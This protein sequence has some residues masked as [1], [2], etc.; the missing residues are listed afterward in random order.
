MGS[1]FGGRNFVV[2]LLILLVV[3]FVIFAVIPR[4]G[5]SSDIPLLG[6]SESLVDRLKNDQ[7]QIE[8]VEVQPDKVKLEYRD[9][10]ASFEARIPEANFDFFEF[11]N[12]EG[13]DVSGLPNV[14]VSKIGRAHV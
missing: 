7:V 4:G 12:R 10:N 11:L 5:G 6:G 8:A 13:I 3:G 2:Y 14:Q 1:R 9:G